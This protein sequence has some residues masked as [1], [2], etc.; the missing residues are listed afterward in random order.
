MSFTSTIS[1]SDVIG[2]EMFGV[3][4]QITLDGSSSS[5]RLFSITDSAVIFRNLI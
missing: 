1:I 4:G 2:L 3:S 5:T